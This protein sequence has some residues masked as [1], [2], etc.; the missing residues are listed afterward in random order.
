MLYSREVTLGIFILF[1][2]SDKNCLHWYKNSAEG[3]VLHLST[4]SQ[5]GVISETVDADDDKTEK[6]M[7]LSNNLLVSGKTKIW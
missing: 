6:Y 5:N 2:S 4:S 1:L 7:Y 3:G